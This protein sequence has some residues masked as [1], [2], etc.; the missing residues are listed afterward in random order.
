[1]KYSN[2]YSK[3]HHVL[4]LV[5]VSFSLSAQAQKGQILGVS[6]PNLTNPYYVA[7]KKSFEQHA[8]E[9]GFD[10]RILIADNDDARQLSQ[11]QILIQQGVDAVALN[12]VSS[13]PCVASVA[14]LNRANIPVFTINLLPDPEAI[15]AQNLKVEQAVQTDQKSGGL[16]VGEQLLRDIGENGH[17]VI[18]I[19]GEPTSVSANTR[20]DG[21]KEALSGNPNARFV[22]LVNGKV[23]ETTALRVT[24]EMLQGN[25]DINVVFSDTEP[26]TLGAMAAIEQLGRRNVTMY[27]FVDRL[28]VKH[29][30]DN[31]ILKAGAIQEPARLA[32]IQVENIRKFFNGESLQPVINSPPLLVNRDN[33]SEVIDKAY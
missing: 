22:A 6:L 24:T 9:Q 19:V 25:P 11:V 13:G 16:Y 17:A 31:T 33:A 20:D 5:L 28:G 26:A 1:M 2:F 12:C 21:F 4:F 30:Q 3:L 15:A 18:G 27:A 14:E 8:A 29:I 10:A 7:M 32:R 23:E